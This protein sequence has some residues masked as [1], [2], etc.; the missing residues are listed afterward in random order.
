MKYAAGV[1][2]LAVLHATGL[3]T[4][5]A[6]IL[7]GFLLGWAVGGRRYAGERLS[8]DQRMMSWRSQSRHRPCCSTGAGKSG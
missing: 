5:P 7:V 4:G 2:L 1:A 8:A 6:F 3:V